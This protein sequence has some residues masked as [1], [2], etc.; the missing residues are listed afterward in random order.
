[1]CPLKEPNDMENILFPRY[2]GHPI[3]LVEVNEKN[4]S[5][6][7]V[8][9]ATV[10]TGFSLDNRAWSSGECTTLTTRLIRVN[11]LWKLSKLHD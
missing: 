8:W 9:K 6:E 5:A 10:H 11:G 1:M 7:V 4:D 2:L 3:E